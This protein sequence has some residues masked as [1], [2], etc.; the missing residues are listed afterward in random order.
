[1][2]LAI[3]LSIQW[4]AMPLD[5]LASVAMSKTDALNSLV[6]VNKQSVDEVAHV[7][8]EN[9]KLLNMV[10]QLTNNIQKSKHRKLET[11]NNYC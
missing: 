5:N 10:S 7:T 8:K 6:V 2:E 1:M 11:P 3:L 4:L 9:E